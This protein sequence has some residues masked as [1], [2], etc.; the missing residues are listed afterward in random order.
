MRLFKLA[1]LSFIIILV[2]SN[3]IIAQDHRPKI[4]LT[5]SGGGAKGLAHIGLLKA[6]DSA[7]LKVDYITGTS[8]GSIVG[9]LYAIGY[10]GDQ[11]E[12]LANELD[13]NKLLSNQNSI[14][15]IIMEE[16]SEYGR[17][18]IEIP[19]EHG[20]L[21]FSTGII[22][23]AELWL[24]FSELFFPVH[25]IKD[26]NRFSI[27]FKCIATNAS[28]GEAVVM[29]TGEITTAIRAS[30][31]IPSV[32][33][34]VEYKGTKLV[35]GGVVRNFPVS[36]VKAMGAEYV[37]GSKVTSGL[38]PVSKLDNPVN[39]LLNMV[40]F[41]EEEDSKK[42]LA[43][44][45][46]LVN[47]PVTNFTTGSFS[48]S[49]EIMDSGIITGRRL[50]PRLKKLADSIETIYGPSHFS[51][52][53][54]IEREPVFISD[55]EVHGLL[56]TSP[57]F[58]KSMTGFQ[59]G[60]SYTALQ[61]A[62][63][64]RR[65]IGLRYYNRITY[66]L[67]PNADGSSRI[68]FYVTPAT[69]NTAKFGL[70]FNKATG[71]SVIMNFTSRNLFTKNS[72]SL[73]TMNLG[74]NFRIRG[75]HMEYLGK[76]KNLAMI[77]GPHYEAMNSNSYLNFE[78]LGKQKQYY[79]NADLL[80]QYSTN[81]NLSLGAGIKYE[82]LK[83]VPSYKL[84]I[85]IKG[86][87]NFM[88]SYLFFRTNTLDRNIYPRHGFR[89]EGELEYIYTQKGNLILYS[90]GDPI[91]N[92]D[93]LKVDYAP[94]LRSRLHLESYHPLGTRSTITTLL[95]GDINFKRSFFPMNDFN[96]GGLTP[97]FRNQIAF[98][99]YQENMMVTGSA[100]ALQIGFRHE[101]FSNFFL[102]WRSNAMVYD[103]I[104]RKVLNNKTSFLSGHAL[105]ASYL[106]PVGPIEFSL[107]YA[108]QPGEFSTSV[109]I[110]LAF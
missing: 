21:K 68:D 98:A 106:T 95:Q 60:R 17:Y 43:L 52:N 42:D 82:R 11:I 64:V 25:D 87:N 110:G 8:M 89:S 19:F 24:K 26:F 71:M 78:E 92:T 7:G 70:H 45:D 63:F 104:N 97:L 66:T 79:F 6:I 94:Y 27:P 4:G 39:I 53:R 100:V 2:G 81:R 90:A 58:F 40:F 47:M 76:K 20:K 67:S 23:G 36:D 85:D 69:L 96:V 57:A 54:L 31:A 28:T 12:K 10:S 75:E 14:Q 29:D 41:K 1:I 46:L 108:D 5:L 44:C 50:Y 59:T 109:N 105:T 80:F 3:K 30:M 61:L 101:F 22:E 102:Y 33:S 107:M 77:V 48:K 16:K 37:I 51:A 88:N 34:A 93:S 91:L 65:A 56:H 74:E 83:F 86:I 35:D 103:F 99:G 15:G 32:F 55:M 49:H 62:S 73:I 72:R 84:S 18:A 38:L 13:W 9:A